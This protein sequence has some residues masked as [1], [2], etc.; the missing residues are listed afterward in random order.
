MATSYVEYDGKGFWASD[1]DIE[2]WLYALAE[3]VGPDAPQWLR[4]LQDHW[5]VQAT[6][7][8]GGCHDTGLSSLANVEQRASV[9]AHARKTLALLE[10]GPRTMTRESLNAMRLG[11][12]GSVFTRDV[13]TELFLPTARKFIEL[14]E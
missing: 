2:F 6:N 11:G 10:A 7:T 4:A 13:P 14:L 3:A 1:V 12:P 8:F 5:R 9:L